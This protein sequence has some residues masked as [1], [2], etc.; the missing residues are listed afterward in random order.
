VVKQPSS[1]VSQEP[2]RDGI[3]TLAAVYARVCSA[4]DL[5][6]E[7][8]SLARTIARDIIEDALDGEDDLERIY[9][10]VLKAVSRS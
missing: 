1:P 9:E 4:L 8:A 10:R 6:A 7:E 5:H 2:E 3:E